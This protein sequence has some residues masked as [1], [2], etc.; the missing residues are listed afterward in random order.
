MPEFDS[1]YSPGG[2]DPEHV[3]SNLLW[4][5]VG[6]S[7]F[8]RYSAHHNVM[9]GFRDSHLKMCFCGMQIVLN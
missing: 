9:W 7:G 3:P 4:E 5:L 1:A 6:E 8:T 2:F